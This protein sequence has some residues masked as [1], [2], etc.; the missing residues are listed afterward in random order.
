MEKEMNTKEDIQRLVI[1]YYY[2][3][4]K[5]M[6]QVEDLSKVY[7]GARVAES[8]FMEGLAQLEKLKLTPEDRRHFSLLREAFYDVIRSMREIRKGNH[9]KATQ[10]GSQSG[11]KAFRYTLA[12]GIK[13]GDPSE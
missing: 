3:T 13:V 5:Q 11:E 9:T 1:E 4:G 12:V 8:R 2:G 6:Q 7:E 10:Y